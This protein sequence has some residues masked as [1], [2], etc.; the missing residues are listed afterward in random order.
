MGD[1]SKGVVN[2]L[3]L[4]QNISKKVYS[5]C[6]IVCSISFSWRGDILIIPHWPLPAV[7]DLT[8]D[9]RWST[10]DVSVIKLSNVSFRGKCASMGI[11]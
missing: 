4:A 9:D 5:Y 10:Y 11:G 6:R 7:R 2:T 1:I 8:R 3:L